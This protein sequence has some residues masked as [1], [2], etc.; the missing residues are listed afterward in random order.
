MCKLANN[1]IGAINRNLEK[2]SFWQSSVSSSKHESVSTSEKSPEKNQSLNANNIFS[3]LK[4]RVNNKVIIDNFK[5]K[6]NCW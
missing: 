3:N 2:S 6:F 4:V 1:F 5:Y